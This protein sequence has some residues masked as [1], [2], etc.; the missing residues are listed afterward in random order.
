MDAAAS[1]QAPVFLTHSLQDE[2]TLSSHS[3]A[4]YANLDPS[5]SALEITNWDSPHAEAVYQRPD[6]FYAMINDFL[7]TY[8]PEYGL[9]AGR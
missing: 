8:A 5:R 7:Q 4:I 6:D 9:S 2:Y 3:E 1:I